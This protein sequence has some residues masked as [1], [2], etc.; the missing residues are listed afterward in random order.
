MDHNLKKY[1]IL[2]RFNVSRETYIDFEKFVDLIIS[3]NSEINLISKRSVQIIRERHII[4]SAQAIDFIEL[5]DNICS[6]IGTGGGFPGIVLAIMA[7]NVDCKIKFNF[8][9]K[10]YHKSLFLKLASKKLN[11]NTEIFQK[12]VFDERYQASG[13]VIARAFKPLP[14][15]LELIN[16]NFLNCKNLIVFMGK[17]GK[18]ALKDAFKQWDF[19]YKEKKSLTNDDSF[20]L[21]I[22]NIKKKN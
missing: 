9:E 13:T 5:N 21:S 7:K 1:S 16:K 14:I 20:L 8:Y 22:K 11:L 4:D 10:S 2:D 3:R 12:D 17:N 15:V 6:D 18:Q 19:E